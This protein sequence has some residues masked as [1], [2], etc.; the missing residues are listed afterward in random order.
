MAFLLRQSSGLGIMRLTAGASSTRTW[1]LSEQLFFCVSL[2]DAFGIVSA[3][4]AMH[5]SSDSLHI[6]TCVLPYI[7]STGAPQ[8][9]KMFVPLPAAMSLQ[10]AALWMLSVSLFII[11]LEY[12]PP[13]PCCAPCLSSGSSPSFSA[14]S[15]GL[16]TRVSPL[17]ANVFARVASF[18]LQVHYKPARTICQ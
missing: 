4:A 18:H 14:I 10:L 3:D 16:H 13:P 12:A 9:F 7:S 17:S 1:N 11:A 8:P 5:Y 6:D 2:S 15:A